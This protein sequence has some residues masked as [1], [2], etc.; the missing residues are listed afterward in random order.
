MASAVI[1]FVIEPIA[2]RVCARYRRLDI[3]RFAYPSVMMRSVCVR[4]VI[5][6]ESPGVP[7]SR[8]AAARRRRSRRAPARRSARLQR[9]PGRPA[10]SRARTSGATAAATAKEAKLA[11]PLIAAKCNA[12]IPSGGLTRYYG[13]HLR[14]SRRHVRQHAA[15]EAAAA[16][17]AISRRR[18]S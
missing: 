10:R 5:A 12:P 9:S 14:K 15:G 4:S 18:S 2:K 6:T 17:Q 13:T 8:I 11:W 16:R 7:C 1:D 3:S